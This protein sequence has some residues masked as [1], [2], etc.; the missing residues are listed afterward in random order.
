MNYRK[1][2]QEEKEK[3]GIF[4]L[5]QEVSKTN[6]RSN[7]PKEYLAY[8]VASEKVFEALN[9]FYTAHRWRNWKFLKKEDH[10]NMQQNRKTIRRKVSLY[11]LRQL[12]EKYADERT[13]PNS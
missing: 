8:L 12:V 3:Q 4:S 6:S 11:I 9:T 5:E 13:C 2:L 7:N 1:L 10:F